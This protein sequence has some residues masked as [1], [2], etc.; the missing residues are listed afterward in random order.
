VNTCP[1]C[2][3]D[4]EFVIEGPDYDVGIM[5]YSAILTGG[6]C[7]CEFTDAQ[8]GTLETEA[9]QAFADDPPT[10]W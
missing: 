2:G 8:V 9:A 5:G 7:T 3:G 1:E 10:D 6:D 4:L